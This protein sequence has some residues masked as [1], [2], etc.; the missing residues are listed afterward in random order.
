[1]GHKCYHKGDRYRHVSLYMYNY[2]IVTF[3][4]TISFIPRA[5]TSEQEAWYIRH[6][7]LHLKTIMQYSYSIVACSNVNNSPPQKHFIDT[8]RQTLIRF[9]TITSDGLTTDV[10]MYYDEFEVCN[11]LG[12]GKKKHKIGAFTT[13]L[14]TSILNLDLFW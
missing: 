4:F 14:G 2:F 13:L 10:V 3:I 6:D 12:A 5:I 11:P 1:M 8:D 9:S 7:Y